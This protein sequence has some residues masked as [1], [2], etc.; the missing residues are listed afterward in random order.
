[1]LQW[2]EQYSIPAP[3]SGH[4]QY[5]QDIVVER[6]IQAGQT[7]GHII[8]VGDAG[9]HI[10]ARCPVANAGKMEVGQRALIRFPAYPAK[11]YGTVKATVSHLQPLPTA[12]NDQEPAYDITVNLPDT[13]TT[14]YGLTIPYRPQMM[15]QVTIIMEDRSLFDRVFDQLTSLLKA[16]KPPPSPLTD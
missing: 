11:E 10:A 4:I 8:P 13:I 3:V 5:L 15:A 9:Y 14:D 7:I 1:M 16:N 12:S 6:P 2:K